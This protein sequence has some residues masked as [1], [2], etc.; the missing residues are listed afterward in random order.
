MTSPFH[1]PYYT[2]SDLNEIA[3]RRDSSTLAWWA[4]GGAL[5]LVI[6]AGLWWAL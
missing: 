2:L 5:A 3:G 4:A 1:E 6:L